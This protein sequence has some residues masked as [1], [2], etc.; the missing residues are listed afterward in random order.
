MDNELTK[1]M[2]DCLLLRGLSPRTMASYLGCAARF[3]RWAGDDPD[4]LGRRDVEGYLVHLAREHAISPSTHGQY[5]AALR[6]LYGV[7]LERP[8]VTAALPCPRITQGLPAVLS[9]AEVS[10]VVEHSPSPGSRV[11]MMAGYLAGLRVGEVRH[12]ATDAVDRE[13]GLLLVRDGKG[14][15]SRVALASTVLLNAIEEH[16]SRARCGSR[17]LFPGRNPEHP[18]HDRTLN[19]HLQAALGRV[20]IERR[21]VTFHSLRHSFATHLLEAGVSIRDI[22]VLLG[23]RRLETTAR[24]LRVAATRFDRVRAPIEVLL[25]AGAKGGDRP[26]ATGTVDL[27]ES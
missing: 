3:S 22:Q 10:A 11:A 17:W 9:R 25:G 12:L 6:F 21:G 18:I 16:Q 14:G 4:A 5:R 27:L 2:E 24:Y 23:H 26:R 15:D 1:R 13:R 20:G 8:Q 19:R 7:V